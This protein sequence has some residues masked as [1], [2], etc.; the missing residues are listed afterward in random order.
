[1]VADKDLEGEDDE[2]ITSS[3]NVFHSPH[4]GQ[5][6]NHLGASNPQFLQKY[7]FLTFATLPE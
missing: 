5:R 4:A 7:A 6:P 2:D 1:M 3:E